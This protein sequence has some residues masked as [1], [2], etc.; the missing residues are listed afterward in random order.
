MPKTPPSACDVKDQLYER[1]ISAET[2][3]DAIQVLWLALL[4]RDEQWL[5]YAGGLVDMIE[6][7]I[8]Q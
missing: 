3:E 1:I 7:G 2:H 4:E 6:K 8:K 5:Q